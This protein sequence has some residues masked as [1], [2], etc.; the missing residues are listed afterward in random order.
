MSLD[1]NVYMSLCTAANYL[2][3]AVVHVAQS[4][5]PGR[6]SLSIFLIFLHR[7]NKSPS[8]NLE[9]RKEL[10]KINR[11]NEF[12]SIVKGETKSLHYAHVRVY[13]KVII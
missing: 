9:R 2:M 10:G 4:G 11:M 1:D 13:P 3:Q 8:K 6:C 5:I 7:Y 12:M